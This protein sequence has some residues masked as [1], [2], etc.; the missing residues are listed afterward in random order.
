MLHHSTSIILAE[1]NRYLQARLKLKEPPVALVVLNSAEAKDSKH[2]TMRLVDISCV[3]LRSSPNEYIPQGDG[4]VMRKA[5]EAFSLYF[6]FSIGY[7]ESVV[8][9]NLELLSYIAIFFQNKSNFNIQNTPSLQEVGIESFSIELVK[10]SETEKS[11][12]WTKLGCPYS[13]SLLYKMGLIFL[14]ESV[15][16]PNVSPAFSSFQKK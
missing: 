5:P 11:M 15:V 1:L 12:L 7:K 13:P 3:E 6:L 4:F 8:L 2:I 16:S 9:N 10:I 14:G